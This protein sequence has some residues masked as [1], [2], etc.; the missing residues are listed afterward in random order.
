[1]R[2]H[3]SISHHPPPEP[4][5]ADPPL[6]LAIPPAPSMIPV[7]LAPQRL[8]IGLAGRGPAAERRE[9]LL[10]DGGASHILRFCDQPPP[11]LPEPKALLALDLL[12]IADLPDDLATRL[13]A[14]AQQAGVLVN[15]E[16]RPELCDF[17]SVAELRR[18]DLLLAVSTGGHSPGLAAR[19]RDWLAAEFGPEWAAR[20]AQLGTARRHWRAE[21]HAAPELAR[22]TATAVE[23]AGWLR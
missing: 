12:W 11:R 23:Q 21:G 4:K 3:F 18:G 2:K 22:R 8:T 17:H 6:H 5:R 19:I 7:A 14:A 13:A 20:L 9:R 1:M 10:R 16:D 15:V